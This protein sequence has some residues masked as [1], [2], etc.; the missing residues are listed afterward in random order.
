MGKM[1]AKYCNGLSVSSHKIFEFAFLPYI[2]YIIMLNLSKWQYNRTSILQL[3]FSKPVIYVTYM[4]MRVNFL[5]CDLRKFQTVF[6]VKF[7]KQNLQKFTSKDVFSK[8][9]NLPAFFEN[10]KQV[11]WMIWE[12]RA[13]SCV[14]VVKLAASDVNLIKLAFE[15]W[16]WISYLKYNS[17]KKRWWMFSD[18]YVFVCIFFGFSEFLFLGFL[19][20]VF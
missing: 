14:C 6:C 17:L 11:S 16:P 3:M 13:L 10:D 7:K 9:K 18:F 15:C 12:L 8:S 19:L 4:Y 5:R 1:I 2:I 20:G